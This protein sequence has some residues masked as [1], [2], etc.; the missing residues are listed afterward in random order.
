MP[1]LYAVKQSFIQ[2]QMLILE[3][4]SRAL[5]IQFLLFKYELDRSTMHPKFDLTGFKPMIS[6]CGQYISRP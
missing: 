1:N 2:V 6:E 5:C 3:F 4:Q